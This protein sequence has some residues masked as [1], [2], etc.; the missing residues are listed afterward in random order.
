M[1]HLR[2]ARL[3]ARGGRAWFERHGFSWADFLRDGID[4]D[5]LRA[6]KDALA[7]RAVAEAEKEA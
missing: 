3:C 7:A 5:I 6:T 4:A 2:A 1:R